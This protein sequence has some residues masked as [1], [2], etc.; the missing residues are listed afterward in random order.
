M[1]RTIHRYSL[2]DAKATLLATIPGATK[3]TDEIEI[4][5]NDTEEWIFWHVIA[6]FIFWVVLTIIVVVFILK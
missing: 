3:E 6:W 1:K 4:T 5:T 2:E